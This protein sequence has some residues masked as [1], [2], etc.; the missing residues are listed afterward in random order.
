MHHKCDHKE[1]PAFSHTYA[2]HKPEVI[3]ELGRFHEEY[4]LVPADT[5]CNYILFKCIL[6]ELGINSTFGNRTYTPPVLSKDEKLQNHALVL[7]TFN[8]PVNGTEEYELPYLYW[9]PK[10]HNNP[11]KQRYIAGSSKCFTLTNKDILLDLVNVSPRLCLYSS[12]IYWELSSR[13]FRRIAK[14]HMPEVVFTYIHQQH[15]NI[16]FQHSTRPSR[17]IN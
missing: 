17:I 13:N 4:V 6:N 12:R 10:L 7:N 14:M 11:Y 3:N 1:Y 5:A 8:I 9:I 15:P 16:T 2:F